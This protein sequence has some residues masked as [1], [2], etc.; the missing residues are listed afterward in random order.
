M[1]DN[2]NY[3]TNSICNRFIIFKV[4]FLLLLLISNKL[5][6]TIANYI[7]IVAFKFND[8]NSR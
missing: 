5:L 2:G 4:Y 7:S 3:Q 6:I 1:I 8:I